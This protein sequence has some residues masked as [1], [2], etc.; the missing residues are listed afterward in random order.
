[1]PRDVLPLR[2]NRD[3][4]L[5]WSGSAVSM[6][7]S[8]ASGVAYPLL[9]LALT[10]APGDAGLAGFVALLPQLLFQVPAGVVVD[11]VDR[12]RLM[13]ACDLLCVAAIGSLAAALLAGRLTLP[14]ILVVGFVE[15]VLAVTYRLAAASAVPH[16]VHPSQVTFALSRNEAR[17]RGAAMLGQPLG[18]TLFGLGRAVPFLFDLGTYLVSLV[19]LLLIKGDF[20]RAR[21]PRAARSAP[22]RREF[23][24]GAVWLWGQPF[25]RAT[26]LLVAGSNFLF[27]ALFLV[28]IVLAADRGAGPATVGVMLGVAAVGG[29]A[30][31]LAAPAVVARIS[32]KA[33]VVGANW[34]W[35]VLVPLLLVAGDPLALGAV[36][37][38]MCFVGPLWNVATSAYQL[39]VTPDRLRGRVLGAAGMVAFGAVPLGSV[40]GGYLLSW[41]GAEATIGLL[42]GWML[43]CALFATLS[44]SVRA[45]P[46]DADAGAAV[47]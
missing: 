39:A 40:V 11:R 19:A 43:L 41:V 15:G 34:A 37:A 18:G 8:N 31:S 47:R 13:I 10:G 33:V 45:A 2:R 16:L 36:Y 28:V 42:S 4:L 14:H 27:R 21:A 35:A 32:L 7:G 23:V 1:M 20:Q 29:L 25:L 12:R 26:T 5:L 38:L 22:G 3:F 6:L 17:A 46:A 44:P 30:G 9:V 24:E